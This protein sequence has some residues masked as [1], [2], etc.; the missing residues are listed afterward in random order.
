MGGVGGASG[1][2]R[3]SPAPLQATRHV[4]D[5]HPPTSLLHTGPSRVHMMDEI[6][7]RPAAEE[8]AEAAAAGY[9]E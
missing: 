7:E 9:D 1:S 4:V 3:S 8:E 5:P 6:N 2:L